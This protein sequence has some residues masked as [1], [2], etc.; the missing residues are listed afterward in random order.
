MQNIY[1]LK[2]F[3]TTKASTS[4]GSSA[5]HCSKHIEHLFKWLTVWL[6]VSVFLARDSIIIC[7]ARYMLPPV[8]LSDEWIIQKWLKLGF[9]NF[10]HTKPR[11]KFEVSSSSSFGDMF[12][13]MPKIV[14]V[15]WL[16]PRPLLREIFV[17]PFGIHHTKLRTKFEVS[18]SS[19]FRD[20]A[21]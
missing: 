19:T 8:R 18:S 12:D 14:D 11:S 20:I 2:R 5:E 9:W 6:C 13:S 15:T 21:L 3:S 10:H 17:R 7:L 4:S 1:L 16:R